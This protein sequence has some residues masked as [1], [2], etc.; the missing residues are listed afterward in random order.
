MHG[1]VVT[2]SGYLDSDTIDL[3]HKAMRDGA[4]LEAIA[5]RLHFD[6]EYLGRLLQLPPEKPVATDKKIDLWRVPELESQL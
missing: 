2:M 3:C 5:C 1:S 6:C 4:T